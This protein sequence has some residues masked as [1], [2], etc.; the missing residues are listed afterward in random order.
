M[1]R[2][3]ALLGAAFAA[4]WSGIA[5]ADSPTRGEAELNQAVQGLIAERAVT[6]LNLHRAGRSR[7]INGTAIIFEIG[8][9]IYVNRPRAG[10]ESLSDSKIILTKTIGS[11][12]CR[13][14]VVQLL[15]PTSH[16]SAGSVF[17]GDFTPYRKHDLPARNTPSIPSNPRPIY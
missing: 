4:S 2:L 6:C 1:S 3:C 13:G 10:A 16:I 8:N 9:R 5:L 15:D 7:I 12:I 17:L 14:E 11:Q